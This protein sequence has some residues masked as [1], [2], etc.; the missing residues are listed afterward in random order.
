ML[1]HW[2]QDSD[3]GDVGANNR[4]IFG[5]KA[6][7]RSFTM[8]TLLTGL[9]VLSFVGCG[10]KETAKSERSNS[11]E[12]GDA[13]DVNVG[14]DTVEFSLMPPSD[15]EGV[16]GYGLES[17]M[18]DIASDAPLVQDGSEPEPLPFPIPDPTSRITIKC[19]NKESIPADAEEPTNRFVASPRFTIG[20][21]ENAGDGTVAYESRS[22]SYVCGK[23]GALVSISNL[24]TK[25]KYVL[26]ATYSNAKGVQTHKGRTSFQISQGSSTVVKLFMK[27]IKSKKG[28][29]DVEIIFDKNKKPI[30]CKEIDMVC[31]AIYAPVVCE[32]SA[33]PFD[34]REIALLIGPVKGSNECTARAMMIEEACRQEAQLM[35]E[36]S[37]KPIK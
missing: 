9:G 1:F 31:A 30:A 21:E 11:H 25:S 18:P 32:G 19:K 35:P 17:V 13:I 6:M 28:S 37:C 7:Y 36:I 34:G 29:V 16:E 14:S 3:K 22:F 5:G 24:S 20:L 33:V 27:S 26:D 15:G 10:D 12:S 4:T 8:I 2:S 23:E